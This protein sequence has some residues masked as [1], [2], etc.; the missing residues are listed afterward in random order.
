[1]ASLVHFEGAFTNLNQL[2]SNPFFNE[3]KST[4]AEE[5]QT[6][7]VPYSLVFDESITTPDMAI[8]AEEKAMLRCEFKELAMYSDAKVMEL[9]QFYNTQSTSIEMERHSAL[10]NVSAAEFCSEDTTEVQRVHDYY[11]MQQIHLTRRVRGSLKLLKGAITQF[12]P[13]AIRNMNSK[14]RQ[15]NAKAIAIMTEWY[16]RH[17]DDPYPSDAE[18]AI[19]AD[20]GGITVHQVK[21]WFSN[22]RNRASNTKPKR[23]KRQLEEK[24]LTIC[25][26]LTT[27]SSKPHKM[28]GDII[29]Q[30]ADLVSDGTTY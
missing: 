15:L 2:S 30:L 3:L 20:Q 18:K 21:G 5:C 29:L 12:S 27:S 1:M 7:T 26:T 11:D 25:N 10:A 19:M 6:N 9:E 8:I 4:L 16:H 14:P 28:Y 22:K 13:E 23:Q 17:I 24:L